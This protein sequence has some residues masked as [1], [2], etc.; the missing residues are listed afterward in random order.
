M[1]LYTHPMRP[2]FKLGDPKNVV[3]IQNSAYIPRLRLGRSTD[4]I[5][6][7][8]YKLEAPK[9]RLYGVQS[10][11][12]ITNNIL[13]NE[14]IKIQ[15]SD[16]TISNIL[17][18]KVPKVNIVVNPDGTKTAEVVKDKFGN[19]V[20]VDN[21]V[22]LSQL[23]NMLSNVDITLNN[24]AIQSKTDIKESKDTQLAF[25]KELLEDQK[26]LLSSTKMSSIYTAS[27][28]VPGYVPYNPLGKQYVKAPEY[29]ENMGT[30][31]LYLLSVCKS[32]GLLPNAP[33]I[34]AR[35]PI[36]LASLSRDMSLTSKYI[37]DLHNSRVFKDSSDAKAFGTST[38]AI[39]EAELLDKRVKIMEIVDSKIPEI[40]KFIEKEVDNGI[41]VYDKKMSPDIGNLYVDI[42]ND[43]IKKIAI[44]TSTDDKK[45]L[46]F[47]RTYTDDLFTR[48]FT[49]TLIKKGI[50]RYAPGEEK[51]FKE[52]KEIADNKQLYASIDKI[53]NA[54]LDSKKITTSKISPAT[55]RNT[56][57]K[58]ANSNKFIDEVYDENPTYRYEP[59]QYE[60][61][62]EQYANDTFPD[63]KGSGKHSGSNIDNRRRE[64]RLN[65]K[66]N[67]RKYR[68]VKV[69]QNFA[70]L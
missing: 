21:K 40:Y 50:S 44:T 16:K 34:G 10:T 15:L 32:R 12:D 66:E 58:F 57:L 48:L 64:A 47:Y 2:G 38:K 22:N 33:I 3:N 6:A 39:K 27:K 37:I 45:L 68:S 56:F 11:D 63:I 1:D 52:D 35:G 36:E 65:M 9:S 49:T 61:V 13:K 18:S 41:F 24:M 60:A 5:R 55:K 62:L 42:K 28:S 53:F 8:G 26:I 31:N 67:M 14:G 7:P 23:I 30:I 25:L 70:D 4:L 20:M 59:L 19:I 69:T 54:D 17:G 51:E 43:V 46:K 29:R